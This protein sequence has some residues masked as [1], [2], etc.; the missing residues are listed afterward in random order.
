MP[1]FQ[2]DCI[3][4]EG[5]N[6]KVAEGRRTEYQ[7]KYCLFFNGIGKWE[8][9]KQGKVQVLFYKCISAAERRDVCVW[10][11]RITRAKARKTP[12]SLT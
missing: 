2:L 7:W 5:Q 3:Q 11:G 8:S 4:R 10:G 12:G 9:E 6:V 1:I